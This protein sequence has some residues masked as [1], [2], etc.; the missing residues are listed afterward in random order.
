MESRRFLKE[1]YFFNSEHRQTI[2]VGGVLKQVPYQE[3]ERE[4]YE[5]L[6]I[7]KRAIF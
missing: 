1:R 3:L 6:Y 7:I 5:Q 2:T 4:V